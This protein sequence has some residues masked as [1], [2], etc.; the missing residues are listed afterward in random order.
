MKRILWIG[1]LIA[2]LSS[3]T[4]GCGSVKKSFA[5][6]WTAN[7]GTVNFVQNGSEITGSIQGYGGFWNETLK[8]TINEN[9]EAVFNTDWLGDF[10]LV[11]TDDIFK[12]KS[13]EISFCGIRSDKS[14]ELPA[15]CGFSG[16]WIVPSKSVFLDGSYM[17]LKQVGE[18]VTGEL[19]DGNNKS[20]DS[21]TGKVDWG[22]G[23]RVNGASKQRG[24]LS[25]WINA[26]ETGFEFIYGNSP[27]SQQLC[28]FRDGQ[29]SAYI[30]SFT[31]QP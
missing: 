2:V 6:T 3:I 20:Y 28:A 10:T 16:K 4:F 24:E 18:N 12:S 22:K 26:S 5:G 17:V 29:A 25:L 21:F 23:W 30:G 27:N 11:L 1:L 19:Y 9:D 15:G 8:G 13:G 31:C 7:I 14:Q